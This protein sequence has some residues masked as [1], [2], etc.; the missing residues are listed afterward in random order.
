MSSLFHDSRAPAFKDAFL[1]MWY[2]RGILEGMTFSFD[3][4][5]KAI[6]TRA[7]VSGVK[8]AGSSLMVP[9][10]A[11]T[12][13]VV[14]RFFRYFHLSFYDR[15]VQLVSACLKVT[16][17]R[18]Y[19]FLEPVSLAIIYFTFSWNYQYSDGIGK[20]IQAD[21]ER[22]KDTWDIGRPNM[23]SSRENIGSWIWTLMNCTETSST[24]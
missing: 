9:L 3:S 14:I 5:P 21:G 19:C 2:F 22:E 10:A 20:F 1:Q 15:P 13:W 6:F 4:L 23:M 16:T 11:D 7:I 12:L 24:A 8:H 18:K 17:C